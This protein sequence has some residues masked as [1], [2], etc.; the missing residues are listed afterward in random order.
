M[1]LEADDFPAEGGELGLEELGEA[2]GVVVAHIEEAGSLLG[3]QVVERELGAHRALE[4]VD[5]AGAE[6]EV[7]H[8]RD[9]GVGRGG[10][11]HGDLGGLADGSAGQGNLGHDRADDGTGLVLLDELRV[12]GGA[13]GRVTLVVGEHQLHLLAEDTALGVPFRDGQVIAVLGGDTEGGSLSREGGD[14]AD[15]HFLVLVAADEGKDGA[16]G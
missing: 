13:F 5:E 6:D 15:H 1:A 12:D 7:A 11:N 16:H 10:G 3:L 14:A 9:L 4:G 2:L 8:A